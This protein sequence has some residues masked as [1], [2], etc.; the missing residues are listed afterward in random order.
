MCEGRQKCDGVKYKF[1][2]K[3]DNFP[4][5]NMKYYHFSSVLWHAVTFT[6]ST[7]IRYQFTG[8]IKKEKNNSSRTIISFK[9]AT[10]TSRYTRMYAHSLLF[11]ATKVR[12][13]G[14]FH[15][16]EIFF[17]LPLTICKYV[18]S[19]IHEGTTRRWYFKWERNTTL[20]YPYCI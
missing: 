10:C 1:Y 19:T 8:Y 5:R 13:C 11:E 14:M 18:L 20:Y 12:L 17:N 2:L 4:E 16:Y 6:N 15:T 3:I 9:V 7:V